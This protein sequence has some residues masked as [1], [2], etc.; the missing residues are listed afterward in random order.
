MKTNKPYLLT[1]NLKDV[2]QLNNLFQIFISPDQ[3]I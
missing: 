1:F 2:D 3:N